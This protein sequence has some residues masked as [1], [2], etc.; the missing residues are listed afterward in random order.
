MGLTAKQIKRIAG[1]TKPTERREATRDN[2]VFEKLDVLK[3]SIETDELLDEVFISMSTEEAHATLDFIGQNRGISFDNDF[4]MEGR[5]QSGYETDEIAVRELVLYA[6]NDGELYAQSYE[7]ISKNLA[8]KYEKGSYDPELAIKGW[9]YFVD[10]AAKKYAQDFG[11]VWHQMF[12]KTERL[13]A[14]QEIAESWLAEYE[15][16]RDVPGDEG[17]DGYEEEM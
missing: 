16:E 13:M 3:G 2:E 5:K 14:A 10:A 7:P 15:I 8:K 9:M 1:V 17:G 4:D 12:P 11:G 6:E